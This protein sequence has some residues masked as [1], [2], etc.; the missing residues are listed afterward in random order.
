MADGVVL[1]IAVMSLG[2]DGWLDQSQA[3]TNVVKNKLFI[4][5]V[6]INY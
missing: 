6:K 5:T 4:A 1:Y 2:R 3:S